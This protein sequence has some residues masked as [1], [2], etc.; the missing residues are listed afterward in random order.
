MRMLGRRL[1]ILIDDDRYR[2]LAAV[3]QRRGVSVAMVVREAIDRGMAQPTSE[4]EAAGR[5]ILAAAPMEVPDPEAL[6]AE[7]EDLRGRRG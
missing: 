7:L 4:R 6:R 3:A 2:R 1:H 5:R